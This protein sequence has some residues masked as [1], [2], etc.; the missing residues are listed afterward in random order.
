MEIGHCTVTT[1]QASDT[2]KGRSEA[3]WRQKRLPKQS[4][5]VFASGS[6]C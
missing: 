2:Q 5:V 6:T 4:T 1:Q 3:K